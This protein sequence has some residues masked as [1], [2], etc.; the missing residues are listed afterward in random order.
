MANK[1]KGGNL[2]VLESLPR[3]SVSCDLP[4][5]L[6]DVACGIHCIKTDSVFPNQDMLKEHL[7]LSFLAS[8]REIWIVYSV[9]RK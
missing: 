7:I 5:Q 2:N 3:A 1:T 6:P 9:A 4:A 8:W